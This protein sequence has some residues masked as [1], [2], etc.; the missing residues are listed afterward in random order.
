MSEV[1]FI[2]LALMLISAL[3]GATLPAI[4]GRFRRRGYEGLPERLAADLPGY[5]PIHI[6]QWHYVKSVYMLM[7]EDEL[8]ILGGI[9]YRLNTLGQPPSVE[10][11]RAMGAIIN[12]AVAVWLETP[13]GLKWRQDNRR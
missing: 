12:R 8:D 13:T 6:R 5:A 10:E 7:T 11:A 2:Q 4:F 1:L 3:A 9:Y